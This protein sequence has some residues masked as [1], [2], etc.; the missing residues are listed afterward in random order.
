[1][2]QYIKAMRLFQ[3]EPKWTPLNR[4]PEVDINPHRK[5]YVESTSSQAVHAN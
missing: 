1:M 5:A 4:G 2:M 3:D